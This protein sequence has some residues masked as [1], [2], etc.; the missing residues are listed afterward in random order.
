MD[1]VH[2]FQSIEDIQ[3]EARGWVLKFNADTPP[4]VAD[5]QGMKEWAGRSPAHRAALVRA[6]AFWSDADLLSKLAVP[7]GRFDKQ[8]KQDKSGVMEQLRAVFLS[9]GRAGAFA[10]ALILGVAITFA[11]WLLPSSNLSDNTMFS[12]SV[13]EQKTLIMSDKS[14][15]QLDTNS[16]IQVDYSDGLR[17]IQLL[18]GKAHFE[19]AKNPDRPFEVHTSNGMVW[20]LGTAFSVYV[21]DKY[22]EVIVNE[23]RVALVRVDPLAAANTAVPLY[24]RYTSKTAHV[25]S[26]SAARAGS[27]S[28]ALVT[29][30]KGQS[31]SFNQQKEEIKDLPDKKLSQE[32]AW[33][34]GFLI[35]TGDPLSKVIAEVNRYTKIDIDIPDHALRD[36]AIGGRFKVGE[37]DVLFDSLESGFGVQVSYVDKDHVQLR[38]AN[39]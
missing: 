10:A 36:L 21:T 15:I 5:I 17:R 37:L 23:G 6:E 19:V 4:T 2:P 3:N 22:T 14:Q 33:R 38:S 28:N 11:S 16:K 13:G 31:A 12:T 39:K 30:G 20:A 32:L 29:L 35:F 26:A 18:Q 1:N 9:F 24:E 25:N 27:M 7:L 8:D 34:D